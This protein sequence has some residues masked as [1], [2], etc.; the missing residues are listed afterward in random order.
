[1]SNSEF[2]AALSEGL[3][4]LLLHLWKTYFAATNNVSPEPLDKLKKASEAEGRCFS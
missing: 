4:K 3:A 2:S 1:M